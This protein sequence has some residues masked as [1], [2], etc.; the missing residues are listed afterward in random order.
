MEVSNLLHSWGAW[1]R[2]GHDHLG[3]PSVNTIAKFSSG[4]GFI[5]KAYEGNDA[6]EIQIIDNAVNA[7]SRTHPNAG[8]IVKMT[9]VHRMPV[10]RIAKALD[11]GRG[12]VREKSKFALGWIESFVICGV[13]SK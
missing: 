11:I 12:Q 7:L 1:A 6:P 8:E 13:S 3:Y 10:S 4:T 9:Y 2:K 5:D